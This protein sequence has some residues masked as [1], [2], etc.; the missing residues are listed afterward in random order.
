M[1]QGAH[2]GIHLG[3]GVPASAGS[4]EHGGWRRQDE[5]GHPWSTCR[6]VATTGLGAPGQGWDPCAGLEVGDAAQHGHG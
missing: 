5:E 3:N 2:A 6:S 4:G 1:E